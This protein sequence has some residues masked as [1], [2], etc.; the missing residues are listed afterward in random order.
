MADNV[1]VDNGALTD[2]DVATDEDGSLKHH[3]YMKI[4][5]GADGVFTKVD[6]SNPLPVAAGA[7]AED[8]AL[9]GNPVRQGVRAHSG[10]PTAMSADNDVVSPWADRSG[11][12]V[13]IPHPRQV[14]ITVTPT[15]SAA[16]Y[17]AGDVMGAANTITSAAVATG[18]PGQIVGATLV[19]NGK[20]SAALECWIFAVSPTL[21]N[22]DNGVFDITDAN[23]VTA[24]PV[25]VID[26]SAANYKSASANAVC[27]GTVNGGSPVLSFVT[28]GSAN[29]FCAFMTTG[30][31]T[32]AS[33]SDLVLYLTVNQF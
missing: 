28:S 16:I 13:V 19:D 17:A 5:F 26:F 6:A 32:Y 22:A 21:V 25:G 10:V 33:T 1:T 23:L 15:I 2:Y 12:Q 18:R 24:L 9:S 29:L 7:A 27:N 11:A 4:E 8:A 31:P 14:L 20:Q 3:Q 30:T